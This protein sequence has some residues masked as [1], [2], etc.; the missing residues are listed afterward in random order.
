M[1]TWVGLFAAAFG[2]RFAGLPAWK[3]VVSMVGLVG[4]VQS[5]LRFGRSSRWPP[6]RKRSAMGKTSDASRSVRP[7]NR[8][9]NEAIG[10]GKAAAPVETKER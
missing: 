6:T 3:G 2:L 7:R 1:L 5:L 8:R 4:I 10:G 9:R